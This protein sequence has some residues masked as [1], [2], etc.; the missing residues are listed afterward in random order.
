MYLPFKNM[1][2]SFDGGRGGRKSAGYVQVTLDS[3][4]LRGQAR[5]E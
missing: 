1:F 2:S 5:F 4:R 3:S